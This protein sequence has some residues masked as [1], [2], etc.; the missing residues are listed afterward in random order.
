MTG[1]EVGEEPVELARQ[2]RTNV[3]GEH[4]AAA[5]VLH[6]VAQYQVILQRSHAGPQV[7]IVA[8]SA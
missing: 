3:A 1:G 8:G 4:V 6:R 2:R 5:I 7:G